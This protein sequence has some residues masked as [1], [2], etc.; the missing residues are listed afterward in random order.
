MNCLI[1]RSMIWCGAALL[2]LC[3]TWAHSA[4]PTQV[5][6][7]S[8]PLQGEFK[9]GETSNFSFDVQAA[10][11]VHGLIDS[12]V[13]NGLTGQ[14]IEPNGRTLRV[15]HGGL[16]AFV[17]RERGRYELRLT[18]S[19]GQAGAFS[20]T[21]ST[22]PVLA[23]ASPA[24]RQILS[25][26][27][28]AQADR[29][30]AGD[31]DTTAFWS[32]IAKE[33]TPLIEKQGNDFLVTLLWRGD[34]HTDSVKVTWSL[35][36]VAPVIDLARLGRSD[37]WFRSF[38]F[39]PG[40]RFSY[41]MMPD[42]PVVQG[43]AMVRALA[44][45]SVAQA[46][47]LH[48]ESARPGADA[49]PASMSVVQLPPR[50][51]PSEWTAARPDVP[52]GQVSAFQLNS[53]S[54]GSSRRISVYT[55]PDY[56][57][58]CGPYGLLVLLDG[59]AY[60]TMIPVPTILDN[61]IAARRIEP[62]IAVFVDNPSVEGRAADMYPNAAFTKFVASELMGRIREQFA[63]TREPGRVAI[64]GF[65]LGG[66]A[67]T[68]IAWRRPEIFGA[69]LS[70][71]GSFWWSNAAI[72]AGR[73]DPI[74]TEGPLLDPRI[75]SFELVSMMANAPK[76]PIR[77]YL[78]AGLYEGDLLTG[79]RFMKDVLSAKGYQFQYQEFPG[80]H[81]AIFWRE[82]F[83]DGLLSL[84]GTRGASSAA[85]CG[86]GVGARAAGAQASVPRR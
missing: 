4:A 57:Q 33:G 66:L 17:A 14:V 75:E 47:P 53:E 2:A 36:H 74:L 48:H 84:M 50:I 30:A 81:D 51:A 70:Q 34:A 1:H 58:K 23:A 5:L 38:R 86:S 61:L 52:K 83:A 37:I 59:S 16:V 72:K 77:L 9:A 79:N 80:G 46:D 7:F 3:A 45:M 82:S 29:L 67:A 68:H 26:R 60:Q 25:P 20:L 22:T 62:L 39:A 8:E 54:T 42:A 41:Q 35:F 69:V 71:S 31:A 64:G 56:R 11:F 15:T 78:Q 21:L 55:P 6:R 73:G 76:V 40:T 12:P 43:P 24:A 85:S 65:S 49:R 63:V 18:N 13:A 19:T 32:V 28:Q 27:L 10:Q 44:L